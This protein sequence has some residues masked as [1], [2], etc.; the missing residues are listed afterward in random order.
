MA[1]AEDVGKLT[2][3]RKQFKASVTKRANKLEQFIV[4]EDKERLASELEALKET[5][6][7]F[8][9]VHERVQEAIA[10]IDEREEDDK[11]FYT[12]QA[13]Y[14]NI[15]KKSKNW[16]N[17]GS[18]TP[19]P[20]ASSS[21]EVM[22]SQF[23][24]SLPKLELKPFDGDP[25]KYHTFIAT[26]EQAVVKYV[27]D[28]SARLLHLLQFT[29][30]EAYQAI[31]PCTLIGGT[32]GYKRAMD[33]LYK[34]FGNEHL[35]M[36]SVVNQVRQSKSAHSPDELQRLVDR[37]SNALATLQRLDK[38]KEVDSQV[39]IVEVI[40]KV[41]NYMRNRW[42]HQAVEA[43]RKKGDYPGFAELV[44]FLENEV[45]EAT[46]PVY[47]KSGLKTSEK[48]DHGKS[49]SQGHRT[50]T[51]T[52]FYTKG[53]NRPPCIVCEQ[54]HKV[55][56]C[57]RFKD[58]KPKERLQFVQDKHMCEICL[59]QNHN[60]AQCKSG[61]TCSVPGCGKKHSKFLHLSS[62]FKEDNSSHLSVSNANVHVPK[63]ANSSVYMPISSV[64]VNGSYDA[65]A[66]LDSASTHTFCSQELVKRLGLKGKPTNY[67]L[68]T[69]S[70][71]GERMKSQT[72]SFDI[73]SCDGLESL[74]LKNVVVVDKIP[75]QVPHADVSR[76]DH[77]EGLCFASECDGVQIL[78]GQDHAEAL[79]PLDVKKGNKSEPFAVR[80][81]LGWTLY[82]ASSVINPAS[83]HV[84]S[85]FISSIPE[86]QQDINVLWHVENE[87]IGDNKSWSVEDRKVIDLWEKKCKVID[88]HYE[89]PIP[90]KENASV[91]NN[92]CMAS[93]R[94]KSTK[95][96]LEKRKLYDRYHEEL[97]KLICNNHAEP[98]PQ[99]ALPSTAKV[100]YLPHQAVLSEKKPGKLRVV[101]DCAAKY[102][103]E[104]LN[105][106]CMQGPNLTNKLLNVLLRF[107][108]HSWAFSGD[109]KAM[110]YQV[111][112]PEE[113]R[114]ALRFL[115]FD[116]EGNIVQYRMTRH[117][118]GGIWCAS[119]STFALRQVLKDT[120]DVDPL[121]A[122]LV[123]RSFYVDDC[124]QS[125]PERDTLM[126]ILKNTVKLLDTRGFHLTKF[127]VND[128]SL[129]KQI[130]E[131]EHAE[132]TELVK[133]DTSSKVLGV[134]WD[135]HEDAFKFETSP[136]QPVGE[137]TR[138]RMLSCLSAI[139]DPLGLMNP[140]IVQGKLVLQQA[141][142]CKISWDDEVPCSLQQKWE[143]WLSALQS[144]P[145]VNIPR[146]IKPYKFNDA[147]VE[148]HHFSDASQQAYGSCS[149]LRSVNKAGQ[150]HVA[151]VMS[152]S[153]V[154]P[155]KSITIPRLELQAAVLSAKVDSSLLE[156]LELT[157]APSYFWTDSEIVLRYIRN[158]SRRFHIFVANRVSLIHQLTAVEQWNFVP[159]NQNPADL[160]TR[161]E[162]MQDHDRKVW[163][164]GPQLLH[165]YKDSW[166]PKGKI[167]NNSLCDQDPEV[168][169]VACMTASIQESVS[170]QLFKHYSSWYRLKRAVAW[171]LRYKQ[172]LSSDKKCLK[173]ILTVKE[174]EEAEKI[175]LK[176]V[177]TD[178]FQ[179][180]FK[181]LAKGQAVNRKSKIISLDPVIDADGLLRVSGRLKNA[182]LSGKMKN[183]IILPSDHP[184]SRL[185]ALQ[186]H[187][188]AHCGSEWVTSEI[189]KHFW[190]V[191][192]RALLKSVAHHCMFCK[193]MFAKSS[194][195]K[196]ADLPAERL[197][198][199]HKPFTYVGL[200]CFGH[201]LIKQG[202]A[203]V[204]RY[205]CLFTC[206]N[207]RAVHLEKLNN[208][209][210]DS[211]LNGFRRFVSRRGTPKKV[212]SDNGTNFV[213]GSSEMKK[214]YQQLNESDLMRYSVKQG[215]EWHFNPPHA[216][217]MG[218]I[219]ERLIR[220]VRKV[221]LG[222]LGTHCRISD[223]ELETLFCE[224]ESIVNSRPI[225]KTSDSILDAEALTP[226]HLLLLDNA[227]SLTPG[228]F[229]DSD[230]YHRRWRQVQQLANI[231]WSRWIKLYLPSLMERQKWHQP[232]RNIAKG[233]LV[234]VCTEC[235]PRGL[236]PMGL[237]TDVQEGLDGLVRSAKVKT[238]CTELIRPVTKLVLLEG[239]Q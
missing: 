71:E 119:S 217:H 34:R 234:L 155:I 67:T 190:I 229:S 172:Y 194:S 91:P 46:D 115:W 178:C 161:G 49:K 103:G 47:G 58:M 156:E 112:I 164:E 147:H 212:W 158:E 19:L 230:L 192:V 224:V 216:S 84:V 202:R 36:N 141:T 102:C 168:K 33:I 63:S 99:E 10:N 204:K 133:K 109:I 100:W 72:V 20:A 188:I 197:E 70:R 55:I 27:K 206:L 85:H 189:R 17:S 117:V 87:G 44:H 80:T 93:L 129:L 114:D 213:G 132:N 198:S 79:I 210:T 218:G 24:R 48:F 111:V 43:K 135:V 76:Y 223:E 78:I 128:A 173:G 53:Y 97:M 125:H 196:M 35:V 200:D 22:D 149:Y 116:Q 195:Q 40:G 21:S 2:L 238:R 81:I 50:S 233:D 167:S 32:A 101:F 139:Y 54:D 174:I 122:N 86:I 123:K 236:W 136:P 82:G 176:T 138:R 219:W 137:I 13:T 221:M 163:L 25:L 237:V 106:K 77:L 61:Y 98:V 38:L 3:S 65:T 94:L 60:T 181:S 29:E 170:Q 23:Y 177:Q 191:K 159:G 235:T 227:P 15:V 92:Y 157:L 142:Q 68:N 105:D 145:K 51:A 90:W 5:F 130:P 14:I 89:L 124:L 228:M 6:S 183:P 59:L 9:A 113:D 148:L 146:C 96:S 208:L 56:Y 83:N 186:F 175:I 110:Y 108:E 151:L 12:V 199:G 152:K 180:E 143:N 131:S 214:C 184:V 95:R 205:A 231:F 62:S 220:T 39:L 171:L 160:L 45:D 203:E 187:N 37:L 42:K 66:L 104:S 169:K 154:A 207:T 225:T 88:G 16:L 75:V 73:L 11:Y 57:P 150:V 162:K 134:I 165:S 18:A 8:E 120:L 118:F 226:N 209:D 126:N 166:F 26:F 7:K 144:V 41:P 153:R 140:L 239:T 215:I 69:L 64:K 1:E 232:K 4:E 182:R 193:K 30:G 211:F 31:Q 28:H 185:I 107:R 74:Q 121:V 201:F 127:V 52:S 222:L 179:N